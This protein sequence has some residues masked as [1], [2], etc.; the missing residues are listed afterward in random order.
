MPF[1]EF[2][3]FDRDG[4]FDMAFADEKGILTVLL[5]QQSA[6]S[7]KATNLC[8]DVGNTADLKEGGLYPVFPFG[9]G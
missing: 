6:Q 1:I 7:P 9:E 5:N 3:D 8:N 4:M 2:G